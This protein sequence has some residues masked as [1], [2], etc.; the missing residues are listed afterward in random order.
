MAIHG[1]RKQN[2]FGPAACAVDLV[3]IYSIVPIKIN[4]V[5]H[6]CYN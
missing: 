2:S 1:R 6:M 4:D 3:Y 5:M